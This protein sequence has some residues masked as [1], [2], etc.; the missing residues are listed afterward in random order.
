MPSETSSILKILL[1]ISSLPRDLKAS[2][3]FTGA[4]YFVKKII[5][6]G[7]YSLNFNIKITELDYGKTYDLGKYIAPGGP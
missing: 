3:L 6:L 5:D 7:Y 4:I 1:F 2:S